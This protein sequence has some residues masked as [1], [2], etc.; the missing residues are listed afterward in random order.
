MGHGFLFS[1][2][3][4]VSTLTPTLLSG[5]GIMCF[6]T[7]EAGVGE[8][9]LSRWEILP[10]LVLVVWPRGTPDPQLRTLNPS[11]QSCLVALKAPGAEGQ[12]ARQQSGAFCCAQEV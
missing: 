7:V 8:M 3:I 11:F 10:C 2:N 9:R 12:A 4:G 1:G 6:L 5:L